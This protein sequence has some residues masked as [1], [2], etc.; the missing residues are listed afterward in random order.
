MAYY[1]ATQSTA[2]ATQQYAAT[3]SLAS[4][5]NASS[6]LQQVHALVNSHPLCSATMANWHSCND[7]TE[8]LSSVLNSN[9]NWTGNIDAVGATIRNNTH[10]IGGAHLLIGTNGTIQYTDSGFTEFEGQIDPVLSFVN[11][12]RMTTSGSSTICLRTLTNTNT[13]HTIMSVAI[14]QGSPQMIST[15][16]NRRR[17][18]VKEIIV[19]TILHAII[20]TCIVGPAGVPIAIGEGIAEG[21][22]EC[23]VEYLYKAVTSWHW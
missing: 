15:A 1:K 12:T 4:S 7:L 9:T 11:C 13:N 6:A 17:G 23:A 10:S 8:S 22:A 19:S 14:G 18:C 20:A 5:M 21:E 2:A 3:Q 16:G